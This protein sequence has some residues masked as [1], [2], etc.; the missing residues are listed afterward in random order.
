MNKIQ[1]LGVF[2][3]IAAVVAVIVLHSPWDG[4]TTPDREVGVNYFPL[5]IWN[6]HSNF[7]II[8]WF[9][10]VLHVL[11]A[12]FFIVFLTVAWHRLFRDSINSN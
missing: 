11:V 9:S 2:V 1:R 10:P 8:D 5:D 3:A 6:W 4:Y 12:L 7:P